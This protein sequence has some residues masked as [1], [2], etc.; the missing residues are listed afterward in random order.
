M[1]FLRK[2]ARRKAPPSVP[3]PSSQESTNPPASNDI[4]THE[5]LAELPLTE[6]RQPA[7]PTAHRASDRSGHQYDGVSTGG[8][9]RNHLGD[10]YTSNVTYNYGAPSLP[11]ESTEK[12]REDE[13]ARRREVAQLEAERR[14]EEENRLAREYQRR[15]FLQALRFDVMDSRLATIGLAHADTCTWIAEAPEYVR[16]RD[17][18]CLPEHHGVLWI[19]GNPGCGKSTLMKYA[20]D[21]AQERDDGNII[22][23]FFFNARGQPLEK[24]AEGMYRSLLRQVLSKLPHLYSDRSHIKQQ[25][26]VVETLQTMLQ[27]SVLALK[28]EE[29]LVLYIDALDECVQD[30]VRDVVGNF[31]ELVDLAVS[32]GLRFSICFSSRHYPH[33][34][35]H[36]FEELKLDDQTE[37][38]DDIVKYVH[39]NVS[40]LD[41]PISAKV[42]IEADIKRRSSGIFLWAVLVIKILK[43]KRDNGAP[44]SELMS[45][46]AVVPDKLG[47]LFTSILA[48]CDKGTTTAFHWLLYTKIWLSPTQLYFAIKTS[49]NQLSTGEWDRDDADIETIG[50]F[51][52]RSTRGLVEVVEDADDLD[53]AISDE[54]DQKVLTV[55]FIHESVREHLLEGGLGSLTTGDAHPIEGFAH[56][57]I[58]RCCVSYIELDSSKYLQCFNPG[59][60]LTWFSSR[61]FP[62]H[63]IATRDLLYHA[64]LAYKAG[65]LS[66][67]FLSELPLMLL[68]CSQ[69]QPLSSYQAGYALKESATILFML[70]VNNAHALAGAVLANCSKTGN[71]GIIAFRTTSQSIITFDID[72][73]CH[74][75]FG[76][77]L[78]LA[79]ARD[80]IELMQQILDLGAAIDPPQRGVRNTLV[81]A[82]RWSSEKAVELLLQNGADADAMDN[83]VPV[84]ATALDKYSSVSNDV[85]KLLLRYGANANAA[86]GTTPV[87]I[88]A[89]IKD[90]C[91]SVSALLAHGANLHHR[92][93]HGTA[94][95]YALKRRY[96]ST[97]IVRLLWDAQFPAG[98]WDR[99]VL[100]RNSQNDEHWED[101]ATV[102]R[103]EYHTGKGSDDDSDFHSYSTY[104]DDT[105]YSDG[106]GASDESFASA[107]TI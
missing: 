7:A 105:W 67:E 83:S 3:R 44:L 37:H 31:E 52:T 66:L 65:A 35:M 23:S 59:R 81:T 76:C 74:D 82:L 24:S 95:D 85:V 19:K 62:L 91:D 96:V 46:L 33:I 1:S 34:T 70:L 11:T 53:S 8:E 80:N 20:L 94:L 38:L 13:D 30:E 27:T 98:D 18:S 4:A 45:S 17:E 106:S 36:K 100:A 92:G 5:R 77:V 90:D 97:E 61:R 15:E 21:I 101:A 93:K 60:D 22:A 64:D 71:P 103:L 29:R 43:E 84:L 78:G 86:K 10:V 104:S 102:H 6:E 48:H 51:I 26:W 88:L 68:I 69:N 14:L 12:Q 107:K 16:W 39:S 99:M 40:R 47:S 9:S 32:R 75:V 49:T 79:A 55:Q 25:T 89:V 87:L 41:V 2:L 63:H 28:P 50:R 54:E 72:I 73:H 42:K 56:A 58:A 57:E